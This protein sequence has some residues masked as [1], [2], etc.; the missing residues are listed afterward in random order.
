MRDFDT[1]TYTPERWEKAVNSLK[2]IHEAGV[3]HA[4]LYPNNIMITPDNPERVLWI[5]FDR[6]ESYELGH[7]TQK[8]KEWI[9]GELESAMSLGK[10]LVCF[11]LIVKSTAL[12]S[13]TLTLIIG[14]G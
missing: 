4:D 2:M 3:L 12:L 14:T 10:C 11:V 1:I 8:Q 7:L 5:D 6:A 9:D 13:G